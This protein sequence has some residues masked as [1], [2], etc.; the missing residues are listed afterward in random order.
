MNINIELFKRYKPDRKV[1]I[2][3]ELT[4]DELLA[5]TPATITRIIKEA[6]KPGPIVI[7]TVQRRKLRSTC[8]SLSPRFSINPCALP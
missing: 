8:R 2:I 3:M 4:E 7:P 1:Q 5:I 6:G